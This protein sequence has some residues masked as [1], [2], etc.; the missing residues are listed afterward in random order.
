[1]IIVN[2]STVKYM[3][4]SCPDV[5]ITWKGEPVTT[6]THMPASDVTVV[7]EGSARVNSWLAEIAGSEEAEEAGE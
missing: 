6:R 5:A 3:A 4:D 2:W 7:G 1:M